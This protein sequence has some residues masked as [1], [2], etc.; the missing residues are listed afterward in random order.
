MDAAQDR[1]MLLVGETVYVKIKTIASGLAAAGLCWSPLNGSVAQSFTSLETSNDPLRREFMMPPDSAK[2]R[3]FWY[4]MDRSVTQR[5]IKLDLERMRHVGIG[6]VFNFNESSESF[7]A[8]KVMALDQRVAF[9]TPSWNNAYRYAVT[10][11][12]KLGLE[13]V[14]GTTAGVNNES[15]GPWV[16]PEQAMK[17]LAWSETR[18]IGGKPYTGQLR[19]PPRTVGPF[20]NAPLNLSNPPAPEQVPEI[21]SDVAVIAYRLPDEDRSLADLQPLVTSSSGSLDPH[22]LWDGDLPTVVS[23]PSPGQGQAAW[24]QLD[25]GRP[26]S[27]QSMSLSLQ[28]QPFGAEFLLN[29][30]QVAA[31][32]Q[33]GED[34]IEFHTVATVRAQDVVGVEQTVTFAPVTARYF[35]LLLPTASRLMPYFAALMPPQTEH[36]IAEFVLHTTPRVDPFEQKAGF[37][38]NSGMGYRPTLPVATRDA[39]QPSDVLD[40]TSRLHPDG[41]LDWTPVAGRWA[42]LRMGY[43]LLGIRGQLVAPEADGLEVDKLSR[44]AVKSYLDNYLGR[45]ESILGSNLVGQ[46]GLR[47]MESDS[48][49]IGPQNWTDELPAEFLRRRGYDLH[50]W[51]PALTGRIIDSA[52]STDRF[53]WD[54]R[55]TLGE[56]LAE[57][58]HAQI[59]ALL[60]QRGLIY[61]S[62]SHERGRQFVGDGMDTKR[63]ND[64]PMGAM[65]TPGAWSAG[66]VP[67][68]ASDSDLRE[69][70]SVAHIYG[71]NLVAAESMSAAAEFGTAYTFS[72]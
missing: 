56:L 20:Q 4:W 43:S 36:R 37:S 58:Y 33:C 41:S 19:Q 50:P 38:V 59:A 55:R 61:Y 44:T 64:V 9:M 49:E 69:S 65:W 1:I 40:L 47:A 66:G 12:D 6:G 63:D 35:R 51:L 13:F 54:F 25:F 21:Y 70:A 60:H 17:K 62:E 8:P 10:L 32:L 27:M 53:L 42:I 2:P 48:W 31:E 3:V 71:Q 23:L 5:G 29:P 39:I 67:Q 52:K 11:A 15:A 30:S 72:P 45:Y 46:H 24:I 68:D 26:Q 28:D 14:A 16:L 34:G 7:F 18:V 22:L 57:N